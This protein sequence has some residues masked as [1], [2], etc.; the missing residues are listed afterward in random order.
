ML[1]LHGLSKFQKPHLRL[2]TNLDIQVGKLATQINERCNEQYNACRLSSSEG[3]GPSSKLTYG[4]VSAAMEASA[5]TIVAMYTCA[6]PHEQARVGV[7]RLFLQLLEI[8][9]V[10]SVCFRVLA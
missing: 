6:I 7:N 3:Y 2:S 4:T 5:R 9:G 8:L 1:N 10:Y